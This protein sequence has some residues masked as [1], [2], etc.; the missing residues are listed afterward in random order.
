MPDFVEDIDDIIERHVIHK[1][2]SNNDRAQKFKDSYADY[3]PEQILEL[4]NSLTP[5][6]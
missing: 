5:E 4:V 1:K 6:D 3:T 2:F